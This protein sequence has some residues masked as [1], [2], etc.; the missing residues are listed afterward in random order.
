MSSTD[1]KDK[2]ITA[3][4]RSSSGAFTGKAEINV[5]TA[6]SL[7]EP[8]A[9]DK[10]EQYK[11]VTKEIKI[12]GNR[13]I[14]YIPSAFVHADTRESRLADHLVV[15]WTARSTLGLVSSRAPD[16]EGGR[17]IFKRTSSLR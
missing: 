2:A 6:A 12:D 8:F 15:R 17:R 11:P 1:K 16:P 14:L 9:F 5:L 7:E 13:I 4:L 3:E 10:Q